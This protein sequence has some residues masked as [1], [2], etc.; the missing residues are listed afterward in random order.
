[1]GSGRNVT[2]LARETQPPGSNSPFLLKGV[3]MC[4]SPNGK[5]KSREKTLT[6]WVPLLCDAGCGLQLCP[7]ELSEVQASMFFGPL[8]INKEGQPALT[9][10]SVISIGANLLGHKCQVPSVT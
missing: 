3:C 2:R 8:E 5:G 1:M 7:P 6:N 10:F 4:I 9:T